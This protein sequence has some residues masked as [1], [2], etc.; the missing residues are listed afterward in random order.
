MKIFDKISALL[1]PF[2]KKVVK[3]APEGASG[4]GYSG[5]LSGLALMPP[6]P[7]TKNM[8]D[9]RPFLFYIS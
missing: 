4:K 8:R 9:I 6:E 3:D 7:N 5:L 2:S 1:K